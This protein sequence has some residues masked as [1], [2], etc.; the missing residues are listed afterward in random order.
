MN[1]VWQSGKSRYFLILLGM[2]L[3][4]IGC[5]KQPIS[6][7]VATPPPCEKPAQMAAYGDFPLSDYL[8]LPIEVLEDKFRHDPFDILEAHATAHGSSGAMR[9][10]VQFRDC[11]AVTVKWHVSPPEAR[12]YNNDPRRELAAYAIQKLFLDPKD[13]VVPVTVPVCVPVKD[14]SETGLQATPQVEGMSCVAGPAS[15]WLKNV[16]AVRN[17]LDRERFERSVLGQE[18]SDYAWDFANLNIFTYL[19]SHRDGRKGNFLVSTLPNQSRIFSIDNGLAFGG[20]GNPRPDIIRWGHL[21]VEQLPRVTV[22]RLRAIRAEQLQQILGTVAEYRIAP[23]G[24]LR[25]VAASENLNPEV[26]FR[27]QGNIVQIGLTAKEIAGIERRL[28]K[29]IER[30]DSGDIQL[31]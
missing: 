23:D 7:Q 22:A 28:R 12:A 14:L 10:K 20:I 27:R 31:F 25:L 1:G 4:F 30:V 24:R 21:K 6:Y 13:Y 18:K 16:N 29:L 19:I 9:F 5:A 26:G 3:A 8:P 2:G 11:T 17:F 15:V